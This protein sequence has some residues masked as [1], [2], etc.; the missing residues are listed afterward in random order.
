M[1]SQAPVEIVISIAG[2]VTARDVPTLCD[3]VGIVL[4]SSPASSA[5]LDVGALR[6][7]AGAVDVLARV[8]LAL[9]RLGISIRLHGASAELCSLL[10]L[11][12]IADVLGL[13]GELGADLRRGDREPRASSAGASAGLEPVGQPEQ[14][15]QPRGVEEERDLGD[16]PG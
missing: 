15:E 13:D 16:P 12:G 2:A 9:R 6:P 1:D 10:R 11:V 4:A 3:V 14:P 5:V 8:A 7:D